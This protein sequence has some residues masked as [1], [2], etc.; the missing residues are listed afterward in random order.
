MIFLVE[1][2]ERLHS[3]LQEENFPWQG[4]AQTIADMAHILLIL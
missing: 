2:S 1:F 3:P 4:P